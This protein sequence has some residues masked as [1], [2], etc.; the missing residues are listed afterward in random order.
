MPCYSPLKGFKNLDTGG[1]VFKRCS[2]AGEPMEVACGCCLGC[3]LD[4]S[5]IWAMRIVHEATLYDS[6]CFIT[7]TYDDEHLPRLF[8]DDYC[9]P[10]TLVKSDFQKFMKRLRKRFEGQRVRFYHSGEYGEADD[11][12][13]GRPHFHACLFNLDFPDKKLF[14]QNKGCPLFVSETLEKLWPYGFS[15][16]GALTFQSA[17][18]CARYILKKVLG[19]KHAYYYQVF[20]PDTGEIRELEPEFCTMSNRPGIGADWFRKS[21]RDVFPSDSIPVRGRGVE[22]KIPRYYEKLFVDE[23]GGAQVL[24]DVK[25]GRKLFHAQHLSDS[26]ARRLEDRYRVKKAQIATLRRRLA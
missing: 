19:H 15:T 4:R 22:Y 1:I 18:Y 5:L 13:L 6:N 23:L 26:T 9:S 8:P 14:D 10:G 12:Y 3:R 25:R 20:D 7:L 17:A 24:Q 16:V 21:H 11:G 2:V